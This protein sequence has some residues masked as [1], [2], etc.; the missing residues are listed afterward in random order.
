MFLECFVASEYWDHPF[1]KILSNSDAGKS[2]A[3]QAGVV[4][5]KKATRYF[6]DLFT[7]ED[8]EKPDREK[9]TRSCNITAELF[10]ESLYLKTV[11]TRYQ[12]QTWGGT[13]SPEYRVTDQLGPLRD[14]AKEGDYLVIQRHA[15]IENHYRLTL[16]RR[17]SASFSDA[18]SVFSEAT[19]YGVL[20]R[21][22]PVTQVEIEEAA[23]VGMQPKPQF[24]LFDVNAVTTTSVVNKV[25]RSIAFRTNV[26]NLYCCQCAICSEALISPLGALEVDAAHVVP[27]SVLGVDEVQNG[28]ALCKKHHWAFDNGLF[29]VGVDRKIVVPEA[30]LKLNPKLDVLVGRRIVD[31]EEC[32]KVHDDA[33]AWHLSNVMIS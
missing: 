31:A 27:R 29:G 9:P 10:V 1:F 32:F 4:I 28:I 15:V 21:S 17:T 22:P 33:F 20:V 25:A 13:R 30:V 23:R 2:K 18:I 24:E 8:K 7:A 26:I 12:F 3:H 16:I 14:P 11:T 19:D 6:P 5:L